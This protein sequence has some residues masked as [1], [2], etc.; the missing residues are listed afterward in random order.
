MNEM[1]TQTHSERLGRLEGCC[2]HSIIR[3]RYALEDV[4]KAVAHGRALLAKL[5]LAVD[6]GG[7]VEEE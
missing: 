3:L 5:E 6:E 4:E 7:K 1:Q 2:R